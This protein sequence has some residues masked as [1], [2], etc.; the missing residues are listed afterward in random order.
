M[1]DKQIV[2]IPCQR[3]YKDTLPCDEGKPVNSPHRRGVP[4][5]QPGHCVVSDEG[6]DS[7]FEPEKGEP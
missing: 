1:T 2:C 6:E 3:H 5:P 7:F 4:L